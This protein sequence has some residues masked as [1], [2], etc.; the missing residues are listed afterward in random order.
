MS[1]EDAVYVLTEKEYLQKKGFFFAFA[2]DYKA[3][4]S[5]SGSI[6]FDGWFD[7]V[8]A[9]PSS[10]TI[11]T[12]SMSLT[13]KGQELFEKL[14]LS[15]RIPAI[16]RSDNTQ[17]TAYYF[18]G[19]FAQRASG[20]ED[21]TGYGYVKLRRLL[22]FSSESDNS[23]FY[24]KAYIPLME[25]IVGDLVKKKEAPPSSNANT[26]SDL[27]FPAVAQTDGFSILQND[28]WI[29]FYPR[30]VNIGSSLP[31]KWFTEFNRDEE[32]YLRWLKEISDMNANSIRV[33]TLLAPEF[34]SALAYFN[35]TNPQSP[36]WL[37]QEIWPEEE[38]LNGDYLEEDYDEAYREEI[39]HVIDAMHG[40]ANIP[41][42]LYRAY[43]IFSSDV[44]DYIAGYLVGRELEPEEVISTDENNEGYH[45][46]GDYLYT[47]AK[48][49]PTEAWLAMSCDYALA[50][51]AKTYG[52]QHPVGIVSW[53]TLDPKEHDSEW[54]AAGDK[55]L[56]YNDKAQ[57]DINNIAMR[58]AFKAGFFGAYH[59]YPNYPDFMNNEAS[60]DDYEDEE[61]RLRYGGYLKEFMEGHKKYPAIVAEFGL[62]TGMGNAHE[63]PDGYNHGGMSE[64]EQGEGI[65]RM[66]K[67]IQREGY[68][69][70]FIF[71][72]ADEWAKKTWTTEPYMIP[73]ERNPIWHNAMDPEQNYGILAMESDSVRSKSFLFSGDGLLKNMR[74]YVDETYLTIHIE[75]LEKLSFEAENLLI[76]LDTYDA[77]AGERRY[78]KNI[79]ISAPSGMEFLIEIKSQ[80]NASILVHP[81][82]N[83]T[84]GRHASYASS[85]GLFERMNMLINKEQITKSGQV[86]K[87]IYNDISA[88]QYGRLVDNSHYQWFQEGNTI[89]IR[90][91]W[92]LINF[93]DPS[94]MQ[95]LNDER[96]IYAPL[97]D[98]LSTSTSDGIWASALI[99]DS[100]SGDVL[101]TLGVDFAKPLERLRWDNWD[102]P[103]YRERTKESYEIIKEYFYMLGKE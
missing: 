9:N 82:Y 43:G 65:V 35:Q 66:M 54:N 96:L 7:I 91:P 39:R 95:V 68:A 56:Q 38:P 62:S 6:Q 69:G 42:R 87:A 99:V 29:D 40:N 52:W 30:G 94:T 34:Y 13:E 98:E 77:S 86:I 58:D 55:D 57:V 21:S 51:E 10:E 22:S 20:E 89:S 59:I 61:G 88:L 79:D 64:Q 26:S 31:G 11:A 36:L 74:L 12:Y 37:Y 101:S 14:G 18:A 2:D 3:E 100:E 70:A 28:E 103:S 72:W 93:S 78:G 1:K 73:Y 75:L 90:I 17:Y 15:A 80:D 76:G 41:Q 24:W 19:D 83:I 46:D 23:N 25:K 53:P 8:K 27:Y 33:Y 81:G 92:S 49:S 48:A 67:A 102:D 5:V 44:S 60:Y 63:S 84:K 85:D 16:V 71:E 50:Y 45:F 47:E 4:F 97:K 32:L